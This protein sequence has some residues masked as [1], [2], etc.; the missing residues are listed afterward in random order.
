MIHLRDHAIAVRWFAVLLMF[1]SLLVLASLPGAT[2]LAGAALMW[3]IA[4]S[5][6]ESTGRAP[7][8]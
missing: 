4:F 1:S 3:I 7:R 6:F 5:L 2:G 8:N